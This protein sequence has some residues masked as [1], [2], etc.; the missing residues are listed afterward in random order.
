MLRISIF[1]PASTADKGLIDKLIGRYEKEFQCQIAYDPAVF[2]R[3][4]PAEKALALS[5]LVS[6]DSCDVLWALRGGEGTADIL[7]LPGDALSHPNAKNK[8]IIGSSD[9]T[10]LLNY[11]ASRFGITSIHS[12]TFAGLEK[13]MP[14]T[15][16][17]LK[18]Y[19]IYKEH[20][21]VQFPQL[22]PINDKAKQSGTLKFEQSAGGNL[23]L[24]AINRGDLWE[25]DATGKLLFLEDWQEKPH[26]ID[27]TLK[28][29]NR[30][31]LF[32]RARAL[33]I[34]DI[35]EKL[36]VASPGD[37]PQ[38][39]DYLR[40]KLSELFQTVEIP[41]FH[42]KLIGHGAENVPIPMNAQGYIQMGP[43]PVLAFGKTR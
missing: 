27:R 23:S 41:V 29:L 8:I 31:G 19:L 37:L 39:R 43:A 38:Q 32:K 9:V 21:P 40:Q 4:T 22:T 17:A 11:A 7:L 24:M 2:E 1:R 26:V 13:E 6:G 5:Q 20:S 36:T 33:I 12:A 15:V 30:V 28:Y 42:T 3:Q 35:Y 10:A 14:L 25:V 18:R 16:A 34:G